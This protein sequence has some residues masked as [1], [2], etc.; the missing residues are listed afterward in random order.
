[1]KNEKKYLGIDIGGTAIK[2]GIINDAY[3]ILYRS[4]TAVVR[5]GK[6][7]VMET[8]FKAVDKLLDEA[9]LD[10]RSL[11]GIGVSAAGCVDKEKG[12]IAKNGG[13]VPN[14]PHTEVAGLL[15]E[16]YGVPATLV[17]DGNAVAL[18]EQCVGAASGSKDV[19]CIVIGTGI[20]GGIITGGRLLE[21]S[22]GFAGEVGHFPSH[23]GEKT[24]AEGGKGIYFE[25]RAS[26]A[27]LVKEAM[28][29]NSEW[30]NGRKVFEAASAGDE[31]ALALLDHWLDDLAYG[32]TGFVHVLNPEIVLIG[33]GVSAQDDLLIKPLR[34]KV[35]DTIKSDFTDGLEIKA[36][37]LGNDA[38]MIGAV[39]YL[40][41]RLDEESV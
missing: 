11:S 32:I 10:A 40:R 12:A 30:N 41:E 27:A 26:T 19:L 14:W 35:L 1:M 34:R 3:E 25:N 28:K 8:V 6:E 22:R 21:G 13:N 9:S 16:R 4:E 38:G 37:S 5:D 23:I 31:K 17:N 18:G 29:V 24:I 15:S 33:G 20:G 36:A 7:H 39:C 2:M